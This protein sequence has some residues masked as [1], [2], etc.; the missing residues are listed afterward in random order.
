MDLERLERVVVEGGD[1]DDRLIASDELEHFEA[2]ELRHL[3]VEQEQVRL[4]IRDGL[5]RL[6]AVGALGDDLHLVHVSQKFAHDSPRELL[7]V[8]DRDA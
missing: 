5:D 6:E 2:I 3:D 1:E 4:E 7:I 8:H